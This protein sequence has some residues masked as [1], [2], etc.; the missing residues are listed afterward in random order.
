AYTQ[1]AEEAGV[2]VTPIS[3]FEVS[4]LHQS[5]TVRGSV[6]D[7]PHLDD[8]TVDIAI[9]RAIILPD[10]E[11]FSHN[12]HKRP[13]CRDRSHHAEDEYMYLYVSAT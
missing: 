10:F 9:D 5:D 3:L 7:G 4:S 6:L 12:F 1:A 13:R 8:D 2:G 11:T